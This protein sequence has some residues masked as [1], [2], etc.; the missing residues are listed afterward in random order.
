MKIP[1]WC[2]LVLLPCFFTP[3][4]SDCQGACVA[5]G[6]L[7]EHQQQLHQAFN[8]MACLLECKG[9]ISSSLTWELC[10]RTLKLAIYPPYAEEGAVLKS[11]VGEL[12]MTSLDLT[13]DSELQSAAAQHFQ[14]ENEDLDEAPFEP[15]RVQYDSSLLESSEAGEDVQSLALHLNDG[16]G[17]QR[18][19]G[20]VSEQDESSKAVSLSKRF[21]G[22]QRG[23]HGYRKLIGSPARHLQKRY[24]GFIGVR[25]SARKWNSQKRVNQLLRQYLGMRSSRSGRFNIYPVTRVWRQN[26]L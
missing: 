11:T 25:K 26:K 18:E 22:F 13:A 5:C 12:Q 7:L 8:T 23:R 19:S 4:H 3:G 20:N 24:G 15:R 1:L 9:Q 6:L 16:E 21:G 10:E 14:E 17:E 2:L